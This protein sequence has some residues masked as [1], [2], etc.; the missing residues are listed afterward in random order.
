MFLIPKNTDFGAISINFED[1]FPCRET[2]KIEPF[3]RKGPIWA[4]Q[5]IHGFLF[6]KKFLTVC[7][8]FLLRGAGVGCAGSSQWRVGAS[9]LW[10][11]VSKAGGISSCQQRRGLVVPW[12]VGS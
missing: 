5:T 1:E 3:C 10:S 12:H 2:W 7:W 8:V 9:W 4:S 11:T 6:L